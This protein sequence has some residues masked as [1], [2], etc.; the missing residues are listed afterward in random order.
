MASS[1]LANVAYSKL[2]PTKYIN[3]EWFDK[4]IAI[5]RKRLG[6]PLTLGEK[7]V[8]SHLEDAENAEIIRGDFHIKT[9]FQTAK[10]LLN[11]RLGK[12]YLNLKPD[13]VAMQ[14]A[15]AQ[16]AVLQVLPHEAPENV[17]LTGW[18]SLSAVALTR[19]PFPPPCT[20]TISSLQTRCVSVWVC[21][22]VCVM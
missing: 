17:C 3:Y 13:R 14:D 16:M 10:S 5:V 18:S 11:L 4:N 7:I 20:A 12:S 21:V 15:T 1:A 22:C 19:L 2:E 9:D 6:R 8:Y